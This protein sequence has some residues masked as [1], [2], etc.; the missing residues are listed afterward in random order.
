MQNFL[1]VYGDPKQAR[2]VL[3][4]MFPIAFAQIEGLLWTTTG[5]IDRWGGK[6]KAAQR[7]RTGFDS[8][9]TD[10]KLYRQISDPEIAEDLAIR[11]GKP[12]GSFSAVFAMTGHM[13]VVGPSV[14]LAVL[15]C[16]G[17]DRCSS[18]RL[19]LLLPD[20]HG[21]KM[22]KMIT[23]SIANGKADPSWGI[24]RKIKERPASVELKK[25]S[26]AIGGSLSGLLQTCLAEEKR[27]KEQHNNAL[28]SLE[29]AKAALDEAIENTKA[30]VRATEIAER[31]GGGRNETP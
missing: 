16:H 6:A 19:H 25:S 29:R 4:K 20:V 13:V 26:E 1:D 30:I 3:E 31:I 18:L 15:C 27:A 28:A 10:P 14:A 5:E 22:E 24:T 9:K 23:T 12:S 21:Q 7:I 8:L 11:M 17:S 2:Q